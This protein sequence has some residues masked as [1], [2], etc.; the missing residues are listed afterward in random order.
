MEGLGRGRAAGAGEVERRRLDAAPAV[1]QGVGA[2]PGERPA[3]LGAAVLDLERELVQRGGAIEGERG[4]GALG[5]AEGMAVRL[6]APAAGQEVPREHLRLGGPRGF[7]RVPERE[8]VPFARLRRERPG[9]ALADAIVVGLHRVL[10]THP[11]GAD[12][13]PRPEQVQRRRGP[14]ADARHRERQALLQRGAGDGDDRQEPL[15]LCGEAREPVM[16]NAV[17]RARAGGGRSSGLAG[18][19]MTDQLLQEEGV[20]LRLRGDGLGLRGGLAPVPAEQNRARGA[21]RPVPG[22]DPGRSRARPGRRGRY[23]RAPARRERRPPRRSGRSRRTGAPERRAPRAARA[24][25]GR[26]PRRPIAGRRRRGRGASG[27]RGGAG[28]P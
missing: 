23:R 19:G 17:E 1:D 7:E 28:S 20:A 18:A 21:P 16:N 8:V 2:L 13:V 22:A 27:E 12:Q 6:V 11:P 15:R 26:C 4:A 14:L 10:V 5:G 3:R 25:D 24:R 9:H